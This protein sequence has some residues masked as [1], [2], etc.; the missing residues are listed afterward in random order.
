MLTAVWLSG[1]SNL[2]NFSMGSVNIHIE[3]LPA[4]DCLFALSLLAPA[5]SLPLCDFFLSNHFH[6]LINLSLSIS[7]GASRGRRRYVLQP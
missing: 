6:C 3:A 1:D 5:L 4:I 2:V 7:T